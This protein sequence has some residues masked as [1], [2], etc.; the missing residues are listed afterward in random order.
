MLRSLITKN[1][2]LFCIVVLCLITAC[3]NSLSS[4]G[5]ERIQ[6]KDTVSPEQASDS[7]VDNTDGYIFNKQIVED[8][9]E[10]D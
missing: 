5:D 6:L 1:L 4:E 10:D 9:E 7:D 2:F 3:D 8:D